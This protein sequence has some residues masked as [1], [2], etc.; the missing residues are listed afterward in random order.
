MRIG[1]E[2]MGLRLSQFLTAALNL[3][4]GHAAARDAEFFVG[5]SNV[6]IMH[7]ALDAS[8]L[9]GPVPVRA[10]SPLCPALAVAVRFS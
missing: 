6:L 9:V 1:A 10:K 3:Q 8:C 2:L 5:H 4:Y 7:F